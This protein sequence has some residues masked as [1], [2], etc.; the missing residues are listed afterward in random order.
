MQ[1]TLK[2]LRHFVAT[3]ETGQVS[4][5]ARQCFISQPSLTVSVRALEQAL[6][7]DL[8]T[9]HVSGLVLTAQGHEFLRYAQHVLSMLNLAM[10][11]IKAP[12]S[13]L[14]GTIHL[15]VTDTIAAY[16]LPGLMMYMRRTLPG[17]ALIVQEEDRLL[18]E[19]SMLKGIYDLALVLVSNRAQDA[20]L[21]QECLLKSPRRL[22]T[23]LDHPVSKQPVSLLDIANMP[24]ILLDM[25]EHIETVERYWGREGLE[26]NV[27][28]RTKSIEAVRSL[29]AQN[30]GVTILSDLV[31]RSWSHDG[32]R[33]R[34]HAIKEAVPS[35]DLGLIYRDETSAS[36]LGQAFMKTLRTYMLDKHDEQQGIAVT[37]IIV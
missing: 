20:T 15:A 4:R 16:L 23:S 28:F 22:W 14:N 17:V 29:V 26:P 31:Y 10:E 37:E 6:G 24:Y 36:L 18:I 25:D 34:R 13:A 5:A 11:E 27:V 3:A 9:R 1:I 8:F 35:M 19:E 33:I 12:V 2:Q 21:K 7:V 30:M 32:G